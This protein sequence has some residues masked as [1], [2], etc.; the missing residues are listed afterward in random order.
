MVFACL[1]LCQVLHSLCHAVALRGSMLD[2][3]PSWPTTETEE[4]NT[5]RLKL[6]RSPFLS[7]ITPTC[8]H[9]HMLTPTLTHTHPPPH[10]IHTYLSKELQLVLTNAL[11][12]KHTRPRSLPTDL[13]DTRLCP[14]YQ[15]CQRPD[16]RSSG[17]E[18]LYTQGRW[19]KLGGV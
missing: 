10:T 1:Q 5:E 14:W 4:S 15:C 18:D 12:H 7:S 16:G 19:G 13:L 6:N 2:C 11:F 17:G 3:V 8:P 9:P